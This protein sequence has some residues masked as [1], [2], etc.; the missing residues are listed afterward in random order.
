MGV[1]AWNGY[2]TVWNGTKRHSSTALPPQHI[3]IKIGS[4]EREQRSKQLQ[5]ASWQQP[6]ASL[7]SNSTAVPERAATVS[8]A[9]ADLPQVEREGG[10]QAIQ[11]QSASWQQPSTPLPTHNKVGSSCKCSTDLPTQSQGLGI[12]WHS[13]RILAYLAYSC[14]YALVYVCALMYVHSHVQSDCTCT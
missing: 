8:G 5:T 10:S 4:F 13:K 12:V 9:G 3:F 2:G 14:M 6:S 11:S 1:L 7:P